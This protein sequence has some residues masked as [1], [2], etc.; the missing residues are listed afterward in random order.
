MSLNDGV[1]S[2]GRTVSFGV[3][4]SSIS[5]GELCERILFYR[6]ISWYQ[7]AVLLDEFIIFKRFRFSLKSPR[8]IVGSVRW[9]WRSM[10]QNTVYLNKSDVFLA[11]NGGVQSNLFLWLRTLSQL[12]RNSNS[13][14]F[15]G[16]CRMFCN[17]SFT[18]ISKQLFC[19]NRYRCSCFVLKMETETIADGYRYWDYFEEYDHKGQYRSTYSMSG[20]V[21]KSRGTIWL[22]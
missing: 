16:H 19:L 8:F 4:I 17:L 5:V 9:W 7:N 11:A 22:P 6:L 3:D 2:C 12:W 15:L 20:F 21:Q 14:S 10:F 18:T 13:H 1:S